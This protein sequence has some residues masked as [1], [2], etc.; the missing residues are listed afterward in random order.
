MLHRPRVDAPPTPSPL[1]THRT[2]ERP[3]PMSLFTPSL[4]VFADVLD[5]TV[6]IAGALF[7]T[8][9]EL[10]ISALHD[11]DR[12]VG[13]VL[14]EAEDLVGVRSVTNQQRR[15]GRRGAQDRAREAAL[16]ANRHQLSGRRRVERAAPRRA[17]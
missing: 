5:L 17:R 2:M 13:L 1:H 8:T 3:E 9:E 12:R 14:E 7:I 16:G 11:R 10:A 6:E 4:R 15:P